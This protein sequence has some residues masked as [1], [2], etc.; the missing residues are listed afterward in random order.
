[1]LLFGFRR[2]ERSLIEAGVAL[3]LA[4]IAVAFPMAWWLKTLLGLVLAVVS[5]HLV[6][7]S[8]VTI[9]LNIRSK[10][11]ISLL[12][13]AIIAGITW[14]QLRRQYLNHP[15]NNLD[16]PEPAASGG[17]V[18]K[19]TGISAPV[20][21]PAETVEKL[22]S[23]T[24]GLVQQLREFQQRIDDWNR[25]AAT[26]LNQDI[27]NEKSDTQAHKVYI[28]HTEEFGAS[29]AN[30][31]KEFNAKLKPQIILIKKELISELPAKSVPPKPTV[32]YT[33]NYGFS[34]F[35]N[36]VGDIADYLETLSAKL[37]EK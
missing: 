26:K 6:F 11:G 23:D 13:I 29:M 25:S 7:S 37:P 1:M 31:N 8:P 9:R 36:A 20:T 4:V 21:G 15:V 14:S 30:L 35:P 16:Q 12:A 2:S 28:E 22:K 19:T 34:T 33:L 18:E 3:M 27:A 24:A 32:D 5:A 10:V 17:I